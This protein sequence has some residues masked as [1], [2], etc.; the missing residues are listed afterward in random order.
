MARTKAYHIYTACSFY[1]NQM[2]LARENQSPQQFAAAVDQRFGTSFHYFTNVYQKVKY[3]TTAL[4]AKE[5]D[6]V[7]NFYKP[8]TDGRKSIY[9][10]NQSHIS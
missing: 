2:G 10:A 5:E 4:T 9:S 7:Q 8:R 1:L 6:L 3:S